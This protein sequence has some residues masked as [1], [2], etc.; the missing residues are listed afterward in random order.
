MSYQID[1]FDDRIHIAFYGTLDALDLILLNQSQ[2]Y[3]SAIENNTKMLMDFTDID[4]SA[5]T[6]EDTQGLAMLG[7][8]DSQRVKKLHLV[9]AIDKA[10]APA[11]QHICD[12]IF[13]DSSWQIDIVESVAE[14][15]RVFAH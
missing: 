9:I 8:L 13:S 6:A 3:K 10:S 4:G 14:G 15:K 12:K 7:K 11:I 1:I 5:L 2:D